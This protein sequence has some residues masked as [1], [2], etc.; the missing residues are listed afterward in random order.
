MKNT[1]LLEK[2]APLQLFFEGVRPF[3][4]IHQADLLRFLNAAMQKRNLCS[5]N[6]LPIASAT[7]YFISFLDPEMATRA[8]ALDGIVYNGNVLHFH[9]PRGYKGLPDVKVDQEKTARRLVLDGFKILPLNRQDLWRFLNYLNCEMIKLD[10]SPPW[11]RAIVGTDFIFLVAA[12][13][14]MATR[15]LTHLQ[16]IDY[17]GCKIR[18][19][20]PKEYYDAAAPKPMIAVNEPPDSTVRTMNKAALIASPKTIV[21][22][23]ETATAA[24]LCKQRLLDDMELEV[25][26]A[27]SDGHVIKRELESTLEVLQATQKPSPKAAVGGDETATAAAPSSKQRLIDDMALEL[28]KAKNDGH[29]MKRKLESTLGA[30]KEA[31]DARKVAEFKQE[32]LENLNKKWESDMHETRTQLDTTCQNLACTRDLLKKAQEGKKQVD[33]KHELLMGGYKC[34]GSELE[35]VNNDRNSQQQELVRLREEQLSKD[36]TTQKVHFE[37]QSAIALLEI[38]RDSLKKTTKK[39]ELELEAVRKDRDS[40]DNKLADLQWHLEQATGAADSNEASM[41]TAHKRGGETRDQLKTKDE[42]LE[43]ANAELIRLKTKVEESTKVEATEF[44]EL[45]QNF[46]DS[47]K[48]SHRM[49]DLLSNTMDELIAERRSRRVLVKQIEDLQVDRASEKALRERTES[50]VERLD[51]ELSAVRT[52][53]SVS[54]VNLVKKEDVW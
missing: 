34:L 31:Q 10:P 53:A 38:D 50:Q 29:A 47:E 24:P 26:K 30:L 48:R 15:V 3:Q 33:L 37:A 49:T 39:L 22:G 36:A 8:L 14:E 13:P 20:R 42:M 28:D 18:F 23:D 35:R 54:A 6:E 43:A 52:G 51:A 1:A 12:N 7:C 41:R 46:D 27:K 32:F 16:G 4:N 5:S 11:K 21:G 19:R 2:M 45:K 9:R 44:E 17:C 40:K 25:D